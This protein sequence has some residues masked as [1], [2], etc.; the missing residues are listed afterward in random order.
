M[1]MACSTYGTDE[2]A[3]ASLGELCCLQLEFLKLLMLLN[4]L[5]KPSGEKCVVSPHGQLSGGI[6]PPHVLQTL[7]SLLEMLRGSPASAAATTTLG[8]GWQKLRRA[9]R[10]T[11]PGR[12]V[13][14]S[15]TAAFS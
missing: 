14:W 7:P 13:E 6:S 15:A 1:G 4:T 11:E 9:P 2:K 5:T 8:Q 10:Q 12:T 3:S